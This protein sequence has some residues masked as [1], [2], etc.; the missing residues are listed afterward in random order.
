MK[1]VPEVGESIFVPSIAAESKCNGRGAWDLMKKKG[2]I[3]VVGRIQKVSNSQHF[4]CVTEYGGYDMSW[5]EFLAPQQDT[6][7]EEHGT[8]TRAQTVF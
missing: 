5:E 4:I 3:A 1:K 7:A 2:G 6:L 8:Q